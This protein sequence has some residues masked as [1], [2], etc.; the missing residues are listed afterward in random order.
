M[1]LLLCT[2]YASGAE[3]PDKSWVI[4]DCTETSVKDVFQETPPTGATGI[5]QTTDNGAVVAA[6]SYTHLT[7]PTKA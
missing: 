1:L 7:L 6:V 4:P 2:Q 5:W 3:W